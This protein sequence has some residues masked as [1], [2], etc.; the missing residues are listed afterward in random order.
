[1]NL[2]R[3]YAQ[4]Q[5]IFVGRKARIE[6]N[7]FLFYYDELVQKREHIFNRY[8]ELV[9]KSNQNFRQ[10]KPRSNKMSFAFL[11]EEEKSQ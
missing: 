6:T 11:E 4:E 8:I 5:N 10:S 9:Y 7:A 1:M 2:I 3:Y